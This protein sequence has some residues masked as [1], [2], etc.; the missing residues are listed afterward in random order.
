VALTQTLAQMEARVRYTCDVGGAS[1]TERHTQAAIFDL[2]NVGI[3]KL[4]RLLRSA[5]P[6][7]RWLATNTIA[8][9]SGVSV[10]ALPADFLSLISVELL[11]EGHRRWLT[12]FELA[13][14]A[15]LTDP[16]QSYTGVPTAYRVEGGNVEVLPVPQASGY[17][18]SLWY[19]P[20]TTMLAGAAVLD[21]VDR[22]DD[23]PVWDA[24]LA[25]C[26]RDRLWE[27]HDRLLDRKAALE[28]EIRVVA[29][30]RDINTPARIV[31]AMP[32]DRFG[33]RRFRSGG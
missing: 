9:S 4:S 10:Y 24:C 27:L 17:T 11:A 30:Q 13:E 26:E 32:P 21:T 23:Y 31:D 29:R 33:A 12:A 3:A 14:R 25:V 5:A 8:L 28:K 20:H 2:L 1:G 16:L 19:V 7:Q 22:L 6:D 18:L 15:M